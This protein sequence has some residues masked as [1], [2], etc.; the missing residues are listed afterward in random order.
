MRD[1]EQHVPSALRDI[2]ALSVVGTAVFVA[3]KVLEALVLQEQR[4]LTAP[5]ILRWHR[6]GLQVLVA[7]A[8]GFGLLLRMR[9][10]QMGKEAAR[11]RELRGELELSLQRYRSLFE[12]NP[13][14]AYSFDLD[15]SFVSLNQAAELLT[16]Y[17]AAERLGTSFVPLLVPECVDD[18]M[19]AFVRACAGESP[20]Y[21]TAILHKDGHRI[22][23]AVKNVPIV[24]NGEVVGI[25]G[26]ARDVTWSKRVQAE[27][28][29]LYV[30]MEVA[31]EGIA[32]TDGD[33]NVL[34]VNRA[35]AAMHGY[36][37]PGDVIG[38]DTHGFYPAD[39]HDRL[40]SEAVPRLRAG[41]PWHGEVTAARLDGTTFTAEMSVS[42]LESGEFV[43]VARNVTER[44]VTEEALRDSEQRFRA[45]LAEI[46]EGYFETDLRGSLSFFNEALCTIMDT[47]PERLEGLNYRDFARAED[48]ARIY[49]R[50]NRV[51]RTGEADPGFAWSFVRPDG[52]LRAVET[53]VS[54]R[55]D[56]AG[57][58][59][60]F[61]GVVRDV[62]E[63]KQAEERLRASEERYRLVTRATQE[64]TWD[65]DLGSGITRCSGALFA[66]FGIDEEEIAFGDDWWRSRL[67]PEDEDRILASLEQML[68]SSEGD[69]WSEEYRLRKESGEYT[70]VLARAY[71][72]RDGDGNPVRLVGSMLDITARKQYE[73]DLRSA[74][75]EAEE[76][77]RAKSLFLANMSHELRTP[78]H[79]VIGMVELL[80]GTDLDTEQLE[81]AETVRRSGESLLH[82]IN[83]ILDLS[84]IEAGKL[85]VETADV[86]LRQVVEDAT[87]LLQTAADGKGVTL[88]TGVDP[89]LPHHLRGDRW[90]IGQVLTNL[91][92]NAVKFTDH[93]RVHVGVDVSDGDDETALVRFSV[94][95]TGIGLSGEQQDRLFRPFNQADA[96]TTRRFGG[97][98][99]GLALSKHLV[100]I[101]GGAIWV[102][103][104]PG[105]GSTFTFELPLTRPRAASGE[106]GD[107]PV[108]RR[109][110]PPA[111]RTPAHSQDAAPT[112]ARPRL[113]LVDDS[114]VNRKV[115][116]TMLDK[117]GYD[118]DVAQDGRQAL[119]AF[120]PGRY[121][122]V[123]MDVHM[124]V[125]DGYQAA[126]RIRDAEEERDPA[127]SRTPIIAMT[128]TALEGSREAALA[129][130]MDDYVPKP[131]RAADLE[132]VLDHWR[133]AGDSSAEVEPPV[134]E[135]AALEG[136]RE[137]SDVDVLDETTVA[138]L[139]Q[140]GDQLG[141]DFT[142]SL[143]SEYLEDA[144]GHL[145][146]L[147]E[148]VTRGDVDAVKRTAHTF[149]GSSASVGAQ[150]MRHLLAELEALAD[151][152]RVDGADT[153]VAAVR[154][155][156]A[157]TA[158]LLRVALQGAAE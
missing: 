155:G 56:R 103:S 18:T 114:H 151:G 61:R 104:T 127:A 73:A 5:D 1:R 111:V 46:T 34:Y 126:S 117:L 66:M 131:F 147:E 55:S 65:G 140:L 152:G 107:S 7:L 64:T 128:A 84:K 40:M 89:A 54:L 92:G 87:A 52:A 19:A 144:A 27:L 35:Q 57:A 24:V 25:Y 80:L 105:V 153:L 70:D 39:E 42:V 115:A 74:R 49:E 83:D 17:T 3:L 2:A 76:A 15:G 134:V 136:T 29:R 138:E 51:Y 135:T 13:E 78:M 79:G 96:S 10:R 110:V 44:K 129:S 93:G 33:R 116:W 157:T 21:E 90:R 102:E 31:S 60:G 95:D 38:G 130:G 72:V 133:G 145:A 37:E 59:V 86:D 26:I 68:A 123:L 69:S 82:I 125:L 122:A 12:L 124:P 71:I 156:L 106:P 101:M 99:L 4:V 94:E 98:G 47:E 8:A 41:E 118:V 154:A 137:E 148:A 142:G 112:S 108:T 67:H 77:N 75:R 32:I 139:R 62:T 45:S 85:E 48:G 109:P 113:L 91:V 158:P 58:P 9:Y 14:A 11:N 53:S 6:S 132:A 50:F 141:D 119:D 28:E 16:G 43:S 20:E 120:V 100:E 97:T 149:K 22:D 88:T 150:Q 121:A 30:A 23:I 63:Q 143:L 36:A 81:Y 146:A